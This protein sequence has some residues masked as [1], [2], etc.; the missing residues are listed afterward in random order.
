MAMLWT[1]GYSDG[2]TSLLDIARVADLS[3]TDIRAAATTLAG[4]RL[5]GDP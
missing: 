4:A 2:S 1:L 3:F 5:L